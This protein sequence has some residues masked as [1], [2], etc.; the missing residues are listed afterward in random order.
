MT[1]P[2]LPPTLPPA[3]SLT[4]PLPVP[5][6]SCSNHFYI[7]NVLMLLINVNYLFSL[8]FFVNTLLDS[9]ATFLTFG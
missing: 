2:H 9:V 1:S 4:Q 6:V 7:R 5:N 3:G 8:L